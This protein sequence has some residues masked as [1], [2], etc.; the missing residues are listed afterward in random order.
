MDRY[1]LYQLNQRLQFHC[2][3]AINVLHRQNYF[4]G[5]QCLQ[6]I[7]KELDQYLEGMMQESECM[8]ND[9]Q[10][11]LVQSLRAIMQAQEN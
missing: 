1:D 10:M 8:G 2:R 7:H 11:S 5:M 6:H 4:A 3:C 9:I